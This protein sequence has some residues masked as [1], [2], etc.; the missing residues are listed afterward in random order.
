MLKAVTGGIGDGVIIVTGAIG[1]GFKS[2]TET[3]GL[4]A[5]GHGVDS[6]VTGAGEGISRYDFMTYF[7][8]L[9]LIC[10]IILIL[11]QFDTGVAL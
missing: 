11:L 7:C 2:A 1:G 5:L 9:I 4:G 10:F 6:V 3:V 8:N